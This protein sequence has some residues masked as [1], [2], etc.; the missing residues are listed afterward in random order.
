MHKFLLTTTSVAL[1]TAFAVPAYAGGEDE[2]LGLGIGG[3]VGGLF[4][5]QFGHGAGRVAATTGGVI[6]GGLIGDEVGRS[7]D[8][9][10]AYASASSTDP[11]A[12]VPLFDQDYQTSYTPNYVAPSAPEPS[13]IYMDSSYGGYCREFSQHVQMGN[14]IQENYGTACLQPDG[15]WR[16]VQ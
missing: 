5:N 6:V 1:L 16:V 10:N 9:S 4:G 3:A 13:A 11:Y 14:H 8:R 2:L 15:S 12:R 7:L